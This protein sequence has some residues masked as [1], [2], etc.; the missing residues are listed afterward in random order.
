MFAARV[1]VIS[2]VGHEVDVTIAD[3]VADLRAPTPSAAA[4][5]VAPD[6]RELLGEVEATRDRLRESMA[7]QVADAHDRLARARVRLAHA[8][9]AYTIVR[10]RDRLATLR[11][12][13]GQTLRHNWELSKQRIDA[14]ERQLLALDPRAVLARGYA[15]VEDA[16]DGLPITSAADT[17]PAQP[18]RITV[19]DGTFEADVSTKYEVRSTHY[20]PQRRQG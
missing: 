6:I 17:Y 2:G 11:H 10:G 1:P 4:E 9:P 12:R 18:L 14:L 7:D 19:A 15:V 3:F 16:T 13:A 8:S 20:T 5:L